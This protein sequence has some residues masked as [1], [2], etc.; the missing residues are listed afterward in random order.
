LV[1]AY[2]PATHRLLP[3]WLAALSLSLS[4]IFFLV[5][6]WLN[7]GLPGMA[8]LLVGLVLNLIVIVAN[9]GWMPISPQAASQLIGGDAINTVGLGNRFGQKDVLLDPKGTHLGFLADRFLLPEWFPYQAAF[10]PGD[11]LI[12]IGVFWL[13]ARPTTDTKILTE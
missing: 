12:A 7:R 11:I 1:I 5:F 4:L 9:G 3:D 13:L 10:S 6:V 8:I 2:L